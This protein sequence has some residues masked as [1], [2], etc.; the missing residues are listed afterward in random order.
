MDFELSK[1]AEVA[2]YHTLGDL[3]EAG[4]YSQILL[5]EANDLC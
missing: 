5:D 4:M 1:A 3:P 2:L